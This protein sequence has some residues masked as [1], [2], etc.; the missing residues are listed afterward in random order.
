MG[1]YCDT[2]RLGCVAKAGFLAGSIVIAHRTP[3]SPSIFDR[4]TCQNV[5]N[6][7]YLRSPNASLQ[8]G[9]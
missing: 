3:S 4:S 9:G 7:P 6:I 2:M 5:R 8:R 1:G